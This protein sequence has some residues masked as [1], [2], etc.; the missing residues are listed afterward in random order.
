MS[1]LVSSTTD[2]SPLILELTKEMNPSPMMVTRTSYQK[3]ENIRP[4]VIDSNF[5]WSKSSTKNGMFGNARINCG[6]R[7]ST[8]LNGNNIPSGIDD[9]VLLR[10]GKKCSSSS[11]PPSMFILRFYENCI[12][13]V[14]FVNFRP[15]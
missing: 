3:K 12:Q 4:N 1:A 9:F 15:S 13:D 11:C 5:P 7:T 14:A 6:R 10:T 8:A 2:I